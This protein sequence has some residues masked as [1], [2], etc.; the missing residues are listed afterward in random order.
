MST[1]KNLNIAKTMKETYARRKTQKCR[2]FKFKVD[3]SRLTSQQ[4]EQ[5]KMMLVESKWIY[6]Y[7]V[8]NCDPYNISDKDLVNIT[9]K[10]KDNNDINVKITHIGSSVRQQIIKQIQDQIKGL[11]VLKK[12]SHNVGSLRFKS[13]Y[14]SVKFKQYGITHKIKDN[15]HIKLQNIKKPIKVHGLKQIKDLNLELTTCVLYFDGYDYWIYLSCYENKKDL[16]INENNIIG[17]DLG[18]KD[19]LTL[20]DGTKIDV[21]V[22]ETERMKKLQRKLAV[23]KRHSNNWYKTKSLISKEWTHICNIKNDKANKIVASICNNNNLIITQNDNLDEWKEEYHDDKNRKIQH[24]ILGRLKSKMN[25]RENVVF[26]DKWFPTTKLCTK[27]GHK[28][29]MP[30]DERTF[31]CANCGYTDDR[32]IHAANN[33]IWLYRWNKDNTDKAGTVYTDKKLVTS[34]LF[35]KNYRTICWDQE[36]TTS[37]ALL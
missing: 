28:T 2:T 33:M 11:S 36:A 18:V 22:K 15:N 19:T 13:E 27:C 30:T 8:G 32:D 14:K 17:V 34:K 1:E 9:H 7:I 31:V 16:N 29:E 37:S 26:L 4:K 6:N 10:D 25:E 5:L 20:S 21:S 3:R 24:S 35:Y 12:N 23:Q